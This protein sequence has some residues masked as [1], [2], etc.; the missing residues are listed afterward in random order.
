MNYFKKCWY[1]TALILG[2]L[3]ILGLLATMLFGLYSL[4][5]NII[6]IF[7]TSFI[8]HDFLIILCLSTVFTFFVC[9]PKII[10]YAIK[11]LKNE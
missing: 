1:I 7:T 2:C 8:A 6:Q 11:K 9:S 4:I 3:G 5:K 10:T